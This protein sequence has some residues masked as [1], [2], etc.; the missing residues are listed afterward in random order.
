MPIGLSS[1]LADWTG[2]PS[3]FEM[4]LAGQTCVA[5]PLL[6]IARQLD[7][8]SLQSLQ[9]SRQTDTLYETLLQQRECS[10]SIH[11]CLV[12]ANSTACLSCAQALPLSHS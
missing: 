5:S 4:G 11:Q 9:I 10:T 8:L 12:C 1:T 7:A 3:G 6:S 2:C